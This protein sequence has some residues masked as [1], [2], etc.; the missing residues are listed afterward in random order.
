LELA[1]DAL[2]PFAHGFVDARFKAGGDLVTEADR[3]VNNVLRSFLPRDGEGWLSEESP[4]DQSRLDD[5][6][7]W[8]IDPL[9]GTAEFVAG[10]PEWCVSIGFVRRGA[11]FAGGIVNPA[12]HETFLG[13]PTTGLTYNGRKTS[14]SSKDTLAGARVLASRSEVKRGEW[15]SFRNASFEITPMGSV[16][17]K[18]ARV[19]AGL[20]DATW[21]LR[22][23]HEWDVAAG[24]ALVEAAGGFVGTLDFAHPVFNTQSALFPGLVASGPRLKGEVESF[25]RE[26]PQG[27][28]SSVAEG[29][30]GPNRFA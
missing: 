1:A 7:V 9:D 14:A 15:E 22:P 3:A 21:T 8:I 27:V 5:E 24:V 6:N 16:A 2:K 20:A 30:P 13:S 12:T 17:Y 4:D 26:H 28:S 18:L 29:T 10:I 19:A 11:A 25:L 23:K